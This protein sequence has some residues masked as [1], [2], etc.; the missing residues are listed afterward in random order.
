MKGKQSKPNLHEKVAPLLEKTAER[1]RN[2]FKSQDL[3][4]EK[5]LGLSREII[6]FSSYTIR[7][8]HRRDLT[9]AGGHL[10]KA[11]EN[12]AKLKSTLKECPEV[13]IGLSYDAQKE[14]A[15]AN[16]TLALTTDGNIPSPEDID[17]GYASYLNGMGEAVGEMRRYLLDSLRSGDLGP[18][19]DILSA[20]DDIYNVLVTMDFPDAMTG[21][22][23]R[24]TDVVRSILEKT[25]GD[26]TQALSQKRLEDKLLKLKGRFS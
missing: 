2:K 22:L 4:R 6:R 3:A 10:S 5:V 12:M 9:E 20:M 24:T 23:R 11:R 16:L 18:C 21:G 1:I 15:E 13:S 19:E 26:L 14:F 7:A 8:I 17:V 25:R